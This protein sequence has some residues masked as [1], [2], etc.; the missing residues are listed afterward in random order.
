MNFL[1]VDFLCF[2]PSRSG[3]HPFQA[4]LKV[5][6]D[7]SL[8]QIWKSGLIFVEGRKTISWFSNSK[9][10][11]HHSCG[12][13]FSTPCLEHAFCTFYSDLRQKMACF[14]ADIAPMSTMLKYETCM[15]AYRYQSQCSRRRLIWPPLVLKGKNESHKRS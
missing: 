5:E 15:V 14:L 3:S 11:F 13:V 6:T 10:P 4:L 9:D 8:E 1:L 2:S 12:Q 7:E